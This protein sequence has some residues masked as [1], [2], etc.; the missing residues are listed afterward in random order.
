MQ[1]EAFEATNRLAAPSAR[2]RLTPP[3]SGHPPAG[4]AGLRPPLMSNVR[5]RNDALSKAKGQNLGE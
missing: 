2:W 5:P 3:S 1:R 4:C